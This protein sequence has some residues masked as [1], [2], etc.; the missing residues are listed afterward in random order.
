M[1]YDRGSQAEIILARETRLQRKDKLV[2]RLTFK[3]GNSFNKEF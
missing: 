1:A 3:N 2:D